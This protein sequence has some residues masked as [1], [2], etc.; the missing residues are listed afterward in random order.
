MQDKPP[1]VSTP[2]G[3]TVNVTSAHDKDR[4]IVAL[5]IRH[6]AKNSS[7]YCSSQQS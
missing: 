6:L 1:E 5:F 4:Q 2:R 3:S 7:R